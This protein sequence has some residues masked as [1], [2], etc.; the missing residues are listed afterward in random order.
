MSPQRVLDVMDEVPGWDPLLKEI[1]SKTPENSIIDWKLLWRNPQPQ[2]ASEGGRVVQLGDSAHSFLPTSGNGATQALEDALSLA[3]CLRLGG[4]DCISLS[5]RAHVLMRLVP[6]RFHYV[7]AWLTDYRYER[8]STLQRFGFVNRQ[9]LHK[10]DL[11]EIEKN[12][13]ILGMRMSRWIWRHD[14]A[15][16]A[17]ENYH[18]AARAVTEGKAFTNTNIPRGFKYEPWTIEEELEREARGEMSTLRDTGDW[19]P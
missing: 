4:K 17:R 7:L 19:T 2:W 13:S 12:P 11:E 1:I 6:C 14:P 18:D 16:Y 10:A 15:R 9:A 8:V 5:T 3:T